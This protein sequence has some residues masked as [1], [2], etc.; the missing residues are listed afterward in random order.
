MNILITC[1]GRR[2]YLVSYFKDFVGPK[3]KVVCADM[4]SYA[5]AFDACD[6]AY[7]TE[8][9]DNMHYLNNII[10]ICKNENIDFAFS[11]ND[12]ELQLLAR[13]K[14]RLQRECST[15]FVVSSARTIDICSDKLKTYELCRQHQVRTAQTFVDLHDAL[16]HLRSGTL[17][18]PLIIK[19]RW[20]SASIGLFKAFDEQQLHD[21]F[22]RCRAAIQSSILAK[23]GP[24]DESVIIQ[25]YLEG[26]EFG[27]DI[28]NNLEGE[29]IGFTAKKKL[30]M[31]AG[32]TDRAISVDPLP[33]KQAA[34]RLSLALEGIGNLDCDFI[35]HQGEMYLLEINPRFGGGYPFTHLS[36]ANH[37]LHLLG[38]TIGLP[39]PT[40]GYRIGEFFGKCDKLVSLANVTMGRLQMANFPNERQQKWSLDSSLDGK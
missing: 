29:F 30:G 10:D 28:L 2:N 36:G 31:R 34:T 8:P 38:P 16:S 11:V 40:Y 24:I 1:A 20:G 22:A 5:A 17:Q 9:V 12:L 18:Y 25:E 39:I 14:Q 33:F 27:V 6:T 23:Q 15:R 19:P 4:T 21:N 32:E 26:A 37:I 13:E 35:E 7:L 3:G